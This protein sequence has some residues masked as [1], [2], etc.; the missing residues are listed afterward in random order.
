MLSNDAKVNGLLLQAFRDGSMEEPAWVEIPAGDLVVTV[1]ADALKAPV[2][3]RAGVRLPVTYLE[4]IEICRGLGCVSPSLSIFD[5]MFAQA[6]AKLSMANLPPGPKMDTVGYTLRFNDL[7]ERKLA[8]KGLGPQDLVFGAWKLWILH[9]SIANSAYRPHGAVNRGFWDPTQRPARFIQQLGIAHNDGHVDYSQV[10]QP[11][12]RMARVAATG[13]AIDLLDVFAGRDRVPGRYLDV[14]R[15]APSAAP[16]APV[17][18]GPRKAAPR[19]LTTLNL[20]A[21]L[22][23]A[24][25]AVAP[26]AGWETRARPG[27]F[28]PQG[29]VVHHTAG[30][31]TGDAPSLGVCVN[32]RPDLAGPLCHVVLARSGTAHL[33]SAGL[34]NHAGMGA[35]EVLALVQKDAPVTGDARQH[36]YVDSVGGNASFYGVEV[37]NSGL[38]GDPYPA[39]Q[40]DALARL[41]AAV[42]KARG[43]SANR[44][45]H[46]RQW[47]ARK[48]DMSYRGDLSGAI[49]AL[50]VETESVDRSPKKAPVAKGA[51][52]AAKK[53][54]AGKAAK[55][56]VAA[57]AAKKVVAAKAS[58]KKAV[59]AKASA[60][61]AV[62]A[63]GGR[64]TPAKAPGRKGG[65]AVVAAT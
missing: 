27:V 31:R 26:V 60:K 36:K 28:A 3:D 10:L 1:A 41:C 54:V 29:I 64:A 12:R 17:P 58:T 39:A 45:I 48:P 47:T 55:K 9:A 25:V 40:L 14:Y 34:A 62:A 20:L 65:R 44:V 63:K 11:V 7:V 43:W 32:G 15:P 23:A 18:K 2:G 52:K 56:V 37:E 22:E 8:G 5:A 57:K 21:T 61:K 4:A 33:V 38:P 46:H 53:A 35:R 24:G 42:C 19:G 51:G 6:R 16:R 50:M 49:A 30:P 59:A 13:A